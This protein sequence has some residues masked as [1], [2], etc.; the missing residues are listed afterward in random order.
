MEVRYDGDGGCSG[1]L[2]GHGNGYAYGDGLG[3]GEVDEYGSGDG[4][5]YGDKRRF[6]GDTKEVIRL[7]SY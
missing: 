1:A 5:G 4:D 3:Y 6:G 2:A 7:R